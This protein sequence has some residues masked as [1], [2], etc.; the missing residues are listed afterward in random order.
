MSDKQL[1]E[2]NNLIITEFSK[3]AEMFG[4]TPTESRLF[5]ILY[6]EG[7]AMT[8]DQMGEALGKSKT[9]ISTSIRNLSD[10]NLVERV[11]KKGVRKD[12]YKAD[13]NLY[14][15]FMTSYIHKWL[16]ATT[17][18]E[19]SLIQ[20][21]N[22]LNEESKYFEDDRDIVEA[23]DLYEKL[24]VMIAFHQLVEKSFKDI[25]ENYF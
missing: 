2:I 4:L 5:A 11:W 1:E 3:T 6:L 24:K 8:L 21:K 22:K 19:H 15:K 12:L 20:I 10:L 23:T 18:Q 25:R 17:R 14:K 13:V 9:S 7:S 16:H